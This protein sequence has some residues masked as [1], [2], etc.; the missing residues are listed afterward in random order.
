MREVLRSRDNE[1]HDR[2][3]GSHVRHGGLRLRGRVFGVDGRGFHSSTSQPN[4]STYCGMHAFP[5][6]LT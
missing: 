5:F 3:R 6:G 2:H 4:I 1:R